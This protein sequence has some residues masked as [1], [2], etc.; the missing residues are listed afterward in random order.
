[1]S[2]KCPLYPCHKM[3]LRTRGFISFIQV[4]KDVP[5]KWVQFFSFQV[6]VH[7][8]VVNVALKYINGW[9]TF[10]SW[11]INGLYFWKPVSHGL[12][13]YIY[14]FV[15]GSMKKREGR[16][17]WVKLKMTKT[18][19]FWKTVFVDNLICIN[20]NL[21]YNL[22]SNFVFLIMWTNVLRYLRV[23]TVDLWTHFRLFRNW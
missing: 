10:Q 12:F 14:I 3:V 21:F 7:D 2:T 8:W 1:M 5:L 9:G 13:D 19:N 15:Y 6:Q 23:W 22:F 17:L 20:V 11:Y 4:Y 16:T 18:L